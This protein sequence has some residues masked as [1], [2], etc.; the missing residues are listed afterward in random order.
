VSKY[1]S[2]RNSHASD[3]ESKEVHLKGAKKFSGKKE[4]KKKKA[5]HIR[6]IPCVRFKSFYGED[7]EI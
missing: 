7:G 1:R 2:Y 5:K 6:T 4:Q 3:S